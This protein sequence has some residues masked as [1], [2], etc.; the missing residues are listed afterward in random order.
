[1]LGD[2]LM[3]AGMQVSAAADGGAGYAH[4]AG[5][6]FRD[7]AKGERR[8]RTVVVRGRGCIAGWRTG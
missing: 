8:L 1:M 3:D 2:G 4:G 5:D 7:A 6:D